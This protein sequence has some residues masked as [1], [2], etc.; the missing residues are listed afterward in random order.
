[1]HKCET[2]RPLTRR[3]A[4]RR[5]GGGFGLVGLASSL[6]GSV[7]PASSLA[8]RPPHFPGKAKHVIFLFLNGGLSQV[9]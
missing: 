4:L 7:T 1:M 3:D 2:A 9:D 5:I 6:Q 8:E